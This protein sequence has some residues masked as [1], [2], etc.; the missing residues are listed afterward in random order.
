MRRRSGRKRALGT[1]MPTA[2]P[3]G[4][5]R[6][7]SHQRRVGWQCIAR[8]QAN[9]ERI[10]RG[11][12]RPAAQRVLNETLFTPHGAGTGRAGRLATGL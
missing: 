4:Q 1:R 12:Q 10:R 11:P 7:G 8:R 9:P 5:N 6:H 3:L 2:L